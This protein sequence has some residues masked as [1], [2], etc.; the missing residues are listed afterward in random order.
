MAYEVNQDD[1]P[2]QVAGS[3]PLS[4]GG[5]APAAQPQ[6]GVQP[7]G[8]PSTPARIQEGASVNQAASQGAAQNK[9]SG[10]A[11]SG[12]FTN[13]QKYVER[14]RPQAQKMAKAVTQDFSRQAGEIAQQ[15]ENQRNQQ[16]EQIEANK[17]ILA[18]QYQQAEGQVA[19]IMGE[20]YQPASQANVFYQGVEPVTPQEGLT[21][22]DMASSQSPIGVTAASNLN[23]GQANMRSQALANLARNAERENFRR[24]L[25]RETF[26]DRQ[27]TRG[28]SALDDLIMGGSKEAREAVI[29]ETQG[30]SQALQ[31]LLSRTARESQ[32]DVAAQNQAIGG[33][34]EAIRGMAA[35][36]RKEVQDEIDARNKRLQALDLGGDIS[37]ADLEALGLEASQVSNLYGM[38]PSD[39]INRGATAEEI[40][41]FDK[42][43]ELLDATNVGNYQQFDK[44]AFL[45]ELGRRR[46][47]YESDLE[48]APSAAR[49]Q[50]L[51]ELIAG[52]S[53]GTWDDSSIELLYKGLEQL[54]KGEK[55]D[56][57]QA[58]QANARIGD[59]Y[60]NLLTSS[61]MAPLVQNYI[62]KR[63]ES[64]AK[65][66]NLY[67]YGQGLNVVE[68]GGIIRNN[69]LR[70]IIKKTR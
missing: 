30:R 63:K 57:S 12:M 10:S 53:R 39:Y 35:D 28:Q 42:L 45:D 5:A 66:E 2:Q 50:F 47:N 48:S 26:G 40:E 8:Q 61:G 17:G 34:S 29:G 69:A 43:G 37:Q 6:G 24:G 33:F 25:M 54:Y 67:K 23:L 56:L 3:S 9:K 22:A 15:V 41:K 7:S 19:D 64:D 13:V 31:R 52:T 55:L 49:K 27:Y 36:P 58:N 60:E 38:D 14:N 11:S 68:N 18:G 62:S 4:Q 44:E 70:N 21:F 16:L 32:E 59:I 51:N 1:Q 65:I 20:G 46:S